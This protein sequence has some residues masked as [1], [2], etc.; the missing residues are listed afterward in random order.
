MK[1]L[2]LVFGCT[3]A[4]LGADTFGPKWT[5][6][7]S[8]GLT[9][10]IPAINQLVIDRAIGTT[11][12]A[13]TSGGLFKTTNSGS[14]WTALGNIVGVNALALDRTSSSTVY[15]GTANGVSKS[16][17]GGASWSSAGLSG[18]PVGNLAIDPVTPS[19]LYGGGKGHLYKST[20]RG[21]SWT[22]LNLPAP[23]SCPI[24][25][26]STVEWSIAALVLDPLT[27]RLLRKKKETS[28]CGLQMILV[29]QAAEYGRFRN[30]IAG[31]QL[32]SVAAFRN[33]VLGG[34]RNSGS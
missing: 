21:G 13:L 30:A 7:G 9:G 24:S 3:L 33:V 17:D 4:L 19:T 26:G 2:A 18:T 27:P 16:T 11:F 12:Y 5:N 32:V 1:K 28:L 31:R 23:C 10:S 8:N 25:P 29:V 6:V 15:A 20:D 34:F 14:S 22:D